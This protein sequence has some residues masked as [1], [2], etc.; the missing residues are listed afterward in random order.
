MSRT[1]TVSFTDP[2]I[3]TLT[4]PT[5]TWFLSCVPEGDRPD[6]ATCGPSDIDRLVQR[7]KNASLVY[8]REHDGRCVGVRAWRG[9]LAPVD[10]YHAFTNEGSLVM[11]DH[12]R[13]VQASLPPA[14]RSPGETAL[15]DHYLSGSVHDRLTISAS[16]GRVAPGDRLTIDLEGR[17]TASAVVDR[18][19]IITEPD[20]IGDVVDRVEAALEDAIRPVRSMDGVCVTFSGGVDSTLLASFFDD[21][22]S[23]VSMTTDSP[24]WA[25]ETEYAVA[26]AELLGRDV[27]LDHVDESD[28]LGHLERTI[29]VMGTVPPYYVLPMLMK[30]YDRPETTFVLGEGADSVFGTDRGLRRIAGGMAN[31]LGMAVLRA[32]GALPGALGF[33]S[34]QI[35]SYADSFARPTE[36]PHSAAGS[37]LRHGSPAVLE[38]IV[39]RDA[40]DAVSAD[41]LRFVLDRV[42]VEM[43]ESQGFRRHTELVLWRHT[44]CGLARVD[45]L[46]AQPNGK[47]IVE[48]YLDWRV[49][50]ELLTVSA[51]RRYVKRLA[52][53]WVLKEILAR[54]VPGYRV[55]QRKNA[56][57]L[58]FERYYVDGPL[59]GIWDRYDVPDFVPGEMR[60][61]VVDSPSPITWFALT[62]AIWSERIEHNA[63]LEPH[64]VAVEMSRP[65]D[66]AR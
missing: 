57:G 6:L 37:S 26:A 44:L 63:S 30:A 43:P 27:T 48:P 35:H 5:G 41:H 21:R 28:F 25:K 32:G 7:S 66:A 65:I 29:G 17:S 4:T 64:P 3:E 11:S 2:D 53:K 14:E 50:R 18:I 58:P 51:D 52:G 1:V 62:H 42:D 20:A 61:A 12:L 40:V 13:N 22:S 23:L 34:R 60:S 46:L 49:V 24:E 59:Q 38:S 9:L 15:I 10:L 36:D 45:R 39:G 47:R 55:N 33:R 19:P 8:V 31:P 54:R 16:V 56:T